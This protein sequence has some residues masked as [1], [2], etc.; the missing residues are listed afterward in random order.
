MNKREEKL[1]KVEELQGKKDSVTVQLESIVKVKQFV[2]FPVL[3]GRKVRNKKFG[4][5]TI[6]ESEGAYFSVIFP[7]G[8]KKYAFPDSFAKGFLEI[9]DSKLVDSC[10]KYEEL[11]R[12]EEELRTDIKKLDEQIALVQTM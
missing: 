1:R 5:G 4:E 12:K 7:T 9:D 3:T 8:E 6:G 11:L 2:Q 10:K